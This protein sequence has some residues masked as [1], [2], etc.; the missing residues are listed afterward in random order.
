MIQIKIISKLMPF[1]YKGGKCRKFIIEKLVNLI[2]R[3]L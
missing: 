2:V 3:G 1:Y